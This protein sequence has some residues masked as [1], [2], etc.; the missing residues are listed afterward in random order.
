MKED[1]QVNP[2]AGTTRRA[3]LALSTGLLLGRTKNIAGP[4]SKEHVLSGDVKSWKTMKE[5][6]G[7]EVAFQFL[8]RSDLQ[9][10]KLGR[11]DIDGDNVYALLTKSTSRTAESGQFES[12]HKYIDVH[13]LLTGQEAIGFFPSSGLKVAVP[14]DASKDVELFALPADYTKLEMGPGRFAIFFPGQA[15]LPMCHLNGPHELHKAV[16]K[17]SAEYQRAH[18]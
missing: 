11:H 8:E 5:L 1:G 18:V 17:V 2:N 13:C 12:H 4:L 7:F 14:Y 3:F 10:L 6:K 15:H 9:E 16:I